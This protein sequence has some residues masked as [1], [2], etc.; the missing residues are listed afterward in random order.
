MNERTLNHFE[1]IFKRNIPGTSIQIS[2]SKFHHY[3]PRPSL[4][5]CPEKFINTFSLIPKT[6]KNQ[7]TNK[8]KA[9]RYFLVGS[10]TRLESRQDKP[11]VSYM[12]FI[13]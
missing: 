5:K 11:N 8:A 13:L 12:P 2:T 6:D 3:V 9:Y 10:L 1:I 4:E 7:L